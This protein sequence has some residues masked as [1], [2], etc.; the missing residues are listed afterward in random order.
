MFGYVVRRLGYLVVTL[1]LMSIVVFAV[2]QMLPG[3]VAVMILGDYATPDSLRTLEEKLGLTLPYHEQYLRWFTKML[4]GDFGES[5]VSNRAIGPVL[6]HHLQRSIVLAVVALAA[7][8]IIGVTFGVV[9]AIWR[10]RWPD[11]TISF[12]SF[13]GISVPEFFWGIVLILLFAGY[14]GW[15]PSYGY[16]EFSQSPA[17]W[18][19]HLVLPVAT[20]AFSFS[21]HVVRLTRTSMI[22]VLGANY[23]RAVRA[24]GF[25]EWTVVVRHALRNALLPT[26][27]VLALDV[28]S[29]IGGLVVVETVFGYPGFGRL[30]VESIQYRDIPVIQASVLVL[31]GIFVAMNLVA[32][33]SYAFLDPRIRYTTE[34]S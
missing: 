29:L 33:V 32:D 34:K 28:G 9:A 17:R 16:T 11:L 18:A 1:F 23:I 5:L 26:V 22:E 6:L 2:T 10:N 24:R 8:A 27:T 14:L 30:L 4:S 20:L 25:P 19:Q 15:L 3:N 21:A 13:L 31:S 7:V 12:G